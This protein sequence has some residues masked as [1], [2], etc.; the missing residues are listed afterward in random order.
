MPVLRDKL[1]IAV[2]DGPII[3]EDSLRIFA[4]ILSIPVTF[5][6]FNF[7]NFEIML[8]TAISEKLNRE[9]L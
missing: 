3:F 1:K 7:C 8:L 6:A 4:G 9:N 5:E 2:R